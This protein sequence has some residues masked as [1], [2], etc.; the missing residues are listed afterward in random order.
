MKKKAFSSSEAR[1]GNFL[2]SPTSDLYAGIVSPWTR[3]DLRRRRRL[4]SQAPPR[5]RDGKRSGKRRIHPSGIR[6]PR[7]RRRG[8]EGGGGWSFRW[9]SW[10]RWRWR[11]CRSRSPS[12]SR[13]RP[14]ATL[15]SASSS[16]TSPRWRG[17]PPISPSSRLPFPP[18]CSS[19]CAWK[20]S[21]LVKI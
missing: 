6:A 17:P 16:S 2:I 18:F 21:G 11:R 4:I 20:S 5:P 12:A 8:R 13:R 14:A 1:A 19:L 9:R 15:S 10:G 7:R 3:Q